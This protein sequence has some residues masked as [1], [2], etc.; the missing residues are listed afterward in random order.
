MNMCSLSY[1]YNVEVWVLNCTNVKHTVYLDRDK[2][3][4]LTD[5]LIY[6]DFVALSSVFKFLSRLWMA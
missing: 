2:S 3:N 5:R 1:I 6:W 4:L